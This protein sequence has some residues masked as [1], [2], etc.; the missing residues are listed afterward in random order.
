VN[1][2][3]Q[4]AR[5]YYEASLEK[6]LITAD[7]QMLRI[8]ADCTSGG[9]PVGYVR[10]YC[11]MAGDDQGGHWILKDQLQL[12]NPYFGATMLHCGVFKEG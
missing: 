4:R 12:M 5:R 10:S 1:I 8:S 11:P 2:L 6:A 3:K 9:A 7:D